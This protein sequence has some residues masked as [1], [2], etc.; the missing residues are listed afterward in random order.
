M[1]NGH[2][3]HACQCQKFHRYLVL[4]RMMW[5]KAVAPAVLWAFAA[6]PALAQPSSNIQGLDRESRPI[7]T[8]VPFLTIAPDA[9][10]SAMGDV[11]VALSPD[12][13]AQHWNPSKLAFI[14]SKD[15]G[16]AVSYTPWL[17]KLVGDMWIGYLSAY[18]KIRT[19]QAVGASLR[20]FDLGSMQFTNQQGQVIQD[21]N[22]REYAFDVSYSQKL[23]QRFGMG[24]TAR[25]IYS[26][27]SGNFS[28]TSQNTDSRPGQTAAIDISMFYSHDRLSLAG[29]ELTLNFGAN[30]SNIGPRI[31]YSA[32]SQRD[33]I[34]T[35]LRLGTAATLQLDPYQKVTLTADANKLLV[36]SFPK[37]DER[38]VIVA[39][40]DPRDKNLVQGIFGSFNDAPDGFREEL[41]E[42]NYSIGAEYWYNDLFAARA[43]Y[44]NENRFKGNRQYYTLG[45]GLRYSKFG[46]DFSYLISRAQNHPLEDTLRF[47]L[48]FKFE[49]DEVES[50]QK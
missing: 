37:V 44:F 49:G 26:N 8:A 47:T 39:G 10:S 45:L 33:F 43:G 30:I 27:L 7:I 22:P 41:R 12:A 20:Y 38:G 3:V 40:S 25:Y 19:T 24:V 18:K 29:R 6:V 42:I 14:K 48:L 9:R 31:T 36:P 2:F 5:K 28:S 11:G 17:Q 13:N 35:N 1:P 32:A 16:A 21:F 34:P 50:S 23:S 15:I 46:F 4:F